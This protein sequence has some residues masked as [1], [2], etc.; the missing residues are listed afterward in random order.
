MNARFPS[1]VG[2]GV[3]LVV[4]SVLIPGP[5]H[6]GAEGMP[7]PYIVVLSQDQ[8]VFKRDSDDSFVYADRF[9]LGD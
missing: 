2:F 8:Q 4:F 3:W 1:A 7:C 5:V 6:H 9:V